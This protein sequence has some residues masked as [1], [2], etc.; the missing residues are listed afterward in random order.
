MPK[1]LRNDKHLTTVDYFISGFKP[2]GEQ[3]AYLQ[4]TADKRAQDAEDERKRK[5]QAARARG[6]YQ[7]EG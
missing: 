4:Q 5:Y 3:D 2:M 7:G 1:K 6:K